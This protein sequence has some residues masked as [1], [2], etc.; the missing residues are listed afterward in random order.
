MHKR[1]DDSDTQPTVPRRCVAHHCVAYHG[2]INSVIAYETGRVKMRGGSTDWSVCGVGLSY[3]L[4]DLRN[5]IW[6]CGA[7]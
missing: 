6:T 4:A 2:D 7:V 3:E 1:P 5:C